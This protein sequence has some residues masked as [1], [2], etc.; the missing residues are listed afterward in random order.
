MS[1]VRVC[2]H[3]ADLDDSNN[4]KGEKNYE[5]YPLDMPGNGAVLASADGMKYTETNKVTQSNEIW[6]TKSCLRKLRLPRATY[7]YVGISH[8]TAAQMHRKIA[9]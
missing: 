4:Q 7:L 1:S 6:V 9:R 5:P 2:V 8:S 3:L